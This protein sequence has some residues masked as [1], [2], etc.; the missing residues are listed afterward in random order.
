VVKAAGPPKPVCA[1]LRSTGGE[2]AIGESLAPV[3][4]PVPAPAVAID[5]VSE[6][7]PFYEKLAALA[8][9]RATDH[10]RIA[11][12]GDSNLT[13]DF[14]TGRMRRR[15]S[16]RFGEGGHGFVA[17]GKPWSHYHHMD[18]LHDVVRGFQAYAI[19]TKPTRDGVYGLA[20]IAVENEYQGARTFVATAPDASPIGRVASSFDVFYLA[21]PRGGAFD[22]E[23]DRTRVGHIDTAA[24][25]KALR[26]AHFSAP[27][28]PHRL[29]VVSRSAA[30]IRV[31][32]VAIERSAPGIVVDAF[33][34]GSLNSKTLAR[35]EPNAFRAMAKDRGYDLVILMTGAN[36]VFTMDAVPESIGS[37]IGWLHDVLPDA[38][39]MLMT[40]ADRG[41][42]RPF[43]QTLKVVAQRRE[44]AAAEGWPLWDQ[45]AAMG[46]AGAMKQ[47]VRAGLAY[48]DGVHFTE[49]GGARMGDLFVDALLEG[50]DGYLETHADAGCGVEPSVSDNSAILHEAQ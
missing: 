19:T 44:L 21:R 24:D 18:V 14:T 41:I 13:M 39:V 43:A 46:G 47:F 5:R 17:L 1:P 16:Q 10:V 30:Q 2:S 38:P 4:A 26:V 42:I 23:L 49:R 34:V 32:G 50:F 28:G 40:P 31:F 33:G 6:L 8:R 29:E 37:V 9:G 3:P 48:K 36:D 15:L 12:F 25:D 27:E 7:G 45:F 11:V 20:G 35:T 22:V